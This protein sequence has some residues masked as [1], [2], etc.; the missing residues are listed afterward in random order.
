PQ[1]RY[2][3]RQYRCITYNARGYPPSDVPD[4]DAAYAWERFR[5]DLLA[6]MDALGVTKAHVV[7]LSMGAYAGLQFAL[8]YPDRISALVFASG[9]S[10]APPGEREAFRQ[11]TARGAERM[12]QQGMQAGADVTLVGATRIQLANKDPRGG[13]EFRRYMAEHSARGSALTLK[14]YQG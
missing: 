12:L 10:G 6:V 4:D 3:S 2:F 14:N 5:D 7:G 9:G 13:E 11:G 8:A 1:V